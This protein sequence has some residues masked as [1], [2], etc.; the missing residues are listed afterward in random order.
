MTVRTRQAHLRA[1]D[2]DGREWK[3][4]YDPNREQFTGRVLY[5]RTVFTVQAHVLLSEMVVRG[6]VSGQEPK[7]DPRQLPLIP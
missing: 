3:L 1:T 6:S 7:E 5:S 2:I 4:T